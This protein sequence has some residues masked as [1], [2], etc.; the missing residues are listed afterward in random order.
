MLCVCLSFCLF[1][2]VGVCVFLCLDR[3]LSSVFRTARIVSLLLSQLVGFQQEQEPLTNSAEQRESNRDGRAKKEN[4][5]MR[6][7]ESRLKCVMRG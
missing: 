3:M 2:F 7:S 4:R 1:D 6:I 5:E